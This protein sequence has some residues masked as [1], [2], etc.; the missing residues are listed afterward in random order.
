MYKVY[1][2]VEYIQPVWMCLMILEM[3]AV[4]GV[5]PKIASRFLRKRSAGSAL[6][7]MWAVMLA[8]GQS[9]R[10]T[11]FF[12]TKSRTLCRATSMC[13]VRDD[14]SG[15]LDNCLHPLLSSKMVVTGLGNGVPMPVNNLLRC[16]IFLAHV[17]ATTYSASVVDVATPSCC[18][19]MYAMGPRLTRTTTAVIDVRVSWHVAQSASAIPII[20]P[21]SASGVSPNTGPR[22]GVPF[23]YRP[24]IVAA[25][26]WTGPKFDCCLDNSCKTN[27]MSGW[28]FETDTERNP[29]HVHVSLYAHAHT[30]TQEAWNLARKATTAHKCMHFVYV[31]VPANSDG[32]CLIFVWYVHGLEREN[33]LY[34]T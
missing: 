16:T 24:N 21:S 14:W 10:R 11:S 12:S 30:R 28:L 29:C 33:N 2:E 20:W 13:L 7:K 6:V 18:L 8:I 1:N 23:M 31:Y 3:G 19:H 9:T 32:N 25:A 15:F 22:F 4:S 34:Y 17:L 26:S 5:Y 27:P